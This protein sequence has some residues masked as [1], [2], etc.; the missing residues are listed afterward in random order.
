MA[1]QRGDCRHVR[2][3]LSTGQ[4]IV[5]SPTRARRLQAFHAPVSEAQGA[6]LTLGQEEVP[7]PPTM[8]TIGCLVSPGVTQA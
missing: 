4:I 1:C 8:G 5:G 2:S 7:H 3:S 6:R